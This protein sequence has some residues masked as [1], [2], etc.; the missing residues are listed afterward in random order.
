M[1]RREIRGRAAFEAAS[2]DHAH[3]GF[4]H[5]PSRCEMNGRCEAG[6][7]L[8]AWDADCKKCGCGPGDRCALAVIAEQRELK[9]LREF[10][11]W[12]DSWV[13]NPVGAYSVA[14][15][16]GLFGMTRDKIATLTPAQSQASE[17]KGGGAS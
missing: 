1:A 7:K 14:A 11:N 5:R 4:L 12:V 13:S 8:P 3:S 6:Y 9:Q 15:L 17:T 16:D 2:E 10:V